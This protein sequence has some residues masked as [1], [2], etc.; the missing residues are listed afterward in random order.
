VTARVFA[1]EILQ[2]IS[3]LI[4]NALDAVP[5]SGGVLSLRVRTYGEKVHI[6]VTDNGNGIAPSMSKFLF[7]PHHTT[8]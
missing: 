1:G 6:S 5:E 3:N 7:Q 4:I 2:L 8:K